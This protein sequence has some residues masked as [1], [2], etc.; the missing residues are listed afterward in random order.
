MSTEWQPSRSIFSA[1]GVFCAYRLVVFETRR[2]RRAL[3]QRA[4]QFVVAE[5]ATTA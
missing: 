1:F 4:D 3:A 2:R 5:P